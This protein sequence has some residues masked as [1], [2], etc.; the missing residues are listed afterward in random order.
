M[1]TDGFT[2]GREPVTEHPALT[3]AQT[4]LANRL[5]FELVYR[6]LFLAGDRGVPFALMLLTVDH[7]ASTNEVDALR[8]LGETIRR[9]T[10]L[11]DLVA[12]VEGKRF[13]VLLLGTNLPGARIAADR[14]EGALRG[15]TRDPVSVGV[16]AYSADLSDPAMLVQAAETALREAREGGGGVEMA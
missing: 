14:I 2:L 13:V 11:S 10:R 16:A 4:G 12:Y 1:T 5:H 8:A 9:A 3:D 15:V 7:D 6:Y